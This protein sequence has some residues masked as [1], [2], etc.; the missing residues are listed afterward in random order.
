ME[1]RGFRAA[2]RKHAR[3]PAFATRAHYVKRPSDRVY[4]VTL[5]STSARPTHGTAT[6]TLRRY[7]ARRH[8]QNHA[9]RTPHFLAIL[10]ASRSNALLPI[11]LPIRR[12][13]LGCRYRRL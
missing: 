8:R 1:A 12:V 2:W 3:V 6:Q 7:R 5:L 9:Y 10:D 11:A 4:G 13:N